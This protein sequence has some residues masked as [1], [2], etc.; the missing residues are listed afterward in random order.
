MA[1]WGPQ[2]PAPRQP[3][4]PMVWAHPRRSWQHRGPS[5]DTHVVEMLPLLGPFPLREPV[6][7]HF[8]LPGPVYRCRGV[9]TLRPHVAG[10][11]AP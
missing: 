9:C 5:L 10:P 11:P 6:V 3:H 8:L 2:E 1:K 7:D 4:G